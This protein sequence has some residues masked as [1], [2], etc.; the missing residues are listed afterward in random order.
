[1][2]GR[3]Y[4]FLTAG[5]L[6]IAAIAHAEVP[7]KTIAIYNNSDETIYPVLETPITHVDQWLQ[8]EFATN[9][10]SVDL[11]P[12]TE[13]YRVYLNPKEG[14]KPHSSLLLDAPFYSELVSNPSPSLDNQYI[15]WWT[16]GR[17][18]LY[19]DQPALLRAYEADKKNLIKPATPGLSCKDSNCEPLDIFKNLVSLPLN[20]PYQLIEYTFANIDTK[21]IPYQISLNNVDYDI[22]Y[23]DHTYL[24]VALEP[25]GNPSIGYTGTVRDTESFRNILEQF[26]SDVQWPHFFQTPS[27]PHVR[28][29]GTYNLW[30]GESIEPKNSIAKQK[31]EKLWTN[32]GVLN[33]ACNEIRIVMELFAFNYKKYMTYPCSSHAP[34]TMELLMQHIYGW[35]PFN[36]CP[37]GGIKNALYDTPGADYNKAVAA[38]QALQYSYL[39]DPGSTFNPYVNLIHGKDYLN[40]DAYAFSIDDASGNVNTEGSGIIIAIGGDEGLP[41]KN[42]YKK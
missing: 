28:L 33:E 16:G 39:K 6:F 29:P 42:P 12:H 13:V 2:L 8:A 21:E 34:L 27:Y 22:S 18:Y 19:D 36:E 9:D 40:M 14:I 24:P 37:S 3:I 5:S 10:P 31:M 38:Y 4:Y 25:E 30:I 20:D 41:N 15:N 11:Y 23:V 17:V 26:A 7:S 35:V 32:C 1:M